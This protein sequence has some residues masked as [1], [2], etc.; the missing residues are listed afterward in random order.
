M[1]AT[2]SIMDKEEGWNQVFDYQVL[3]LSLEQHWN[4]FYAEGAP[5]SPQGLPPGSRNE[6]VV[7]IIVESSGW[8]EPSNYLVINGR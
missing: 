6:E 8:R 3:P 4:A 5:Y 7:N 2:P 1:K